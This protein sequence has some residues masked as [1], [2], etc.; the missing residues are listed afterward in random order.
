MRLVDLAI[1]EIDR[2]RL[3]DLQALLEQVQDRD[4]TTLIPI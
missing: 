4:L 2:L 3:L 1:T